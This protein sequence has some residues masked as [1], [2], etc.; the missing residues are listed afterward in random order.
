M[1]T[2]VYNVIYNLIYWRSHEDHW[3]VYEVKCLSCLPELCLCK[4][5]VIS[6]KPRSGCNLRDNA[7]SWECLFLFFCLSFSFSLCVYTYI[8]ISYTYIQYGSIPI[9]DSPH[10]TPCWGH[11]GT[12]ARACVGVGDSLMAISPNWTSDIYFY[13]HVYASF[14]LRF[15]YEQS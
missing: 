7:L 15:R 8:F 5:G 13:I 9:R 10:P 14:L 3:N 12:R 6:T 1:H 11:R 4:I 2:L